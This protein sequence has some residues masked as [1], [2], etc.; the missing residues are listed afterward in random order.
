MIFLTQETM[1]EI[2]CS[3]IAGEAARKLS[4]FL[5][6]ED[7]DFGS[8][9]DKV[10]RMELAVLKLQTIVAV[11]EDWQI[12]HPPLLHW[13]AK[14]KRVAKEGKGLL[15]AHR[16]QL[17]DHKRR[18]NSS[19]SILQDM[20]R[21][22]KRFMPFSYS[23]EDLS[24]ATVKRFERIASG[25]DDFL[26]F[27]E[28]GG[29]PKGLMFLPAIVRSLSAGKSMELSLRMGTSTAVVLLQPW[30][31]EDRDE[32]MGGAT[33]MHGSPP[34]DEGNAKKA[35]LW[36]SYEHDQALE[37]NFKL[38]PPQFS[39]PR[40]ATKDIFAEMASYGRNS[41]DP[42][43]LYMRFVR[44]IQNSHRYGF[45]PTRHSQCFSG[46]LQLPDPILLVCAHGYILP[47]EKSNRVPLELVWHTSPCYLPNKL[48]EQHETVDRPQFFGEL[49]PRV[50]NGGFYCEEGTFRHE[51]QWW[52]P[53]SSTRFSMTPVLSPP[54]T[55]QK[56]CAR[57][58]QEQPTQGSSE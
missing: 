29:H 6:G 13:K 24:V 49:L 1:A 44:L 51:R 50:T 4:S 37:I 17:L 33:L 32:G 20:A 42:S 53:Q 45:E 58:K 31:L 57:Q 35:C 55:L 21:R 48:S 34:L 15:R 43:V 26:K 39:S 14:L 27:V 7:G 5:L 8:H 46:R 9:E 38:L 22:A 19:I 52:C 36:M 40:A 16:K 54:T 41:P 28:C 11:S 47:V 3:A 10:E 30:W 12:T 2:V 23:T 56:W 25:A 18:R